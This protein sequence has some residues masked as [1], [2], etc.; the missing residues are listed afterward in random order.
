MANNDHPTGRRPRAVWPELVLD[1]WTETRA[2]LHLWTQIVGKIRLAHTELTNHWWNTP[3]YLT[4]RG[5]TTSPMPF[6]GG[7]F[8][9][10]FDFLDHHLAVVT[11]DGRSLVIPLYP[12]TVADFYAELMAGLRV[13]GA[14]TDVWTMP[15]EIPDAIPFDVDTTHAAYDAVAVGL[16]W[17][18]LVAAHG[19]LTTFRNRFVGK[20]SPVHLFWGALDLAVTR[21]SGREAPRHA[22]GAPPLGGWVV[23]EAYSHEVSSAGFWPGGG[24]EGSFYSYAYPEPPGYAAAPVGPPGAAY[25]AEAGEFLLPYSAV[26]TAADPEA[27]LLNFLEDTY[28]AAADLGQWDRSHLERAVA[29]P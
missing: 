22:G 18:Q 20:V 8:Q 16:F 26:R 14:A 2:T 10:D 27:V 7:V 23:E 19:V 15:V 25:G 3:L 24:G 28:R 21:F 1:Q 17:R 29:T 12:R 11:S 5:F 9:I 4:A 13:L 6:D